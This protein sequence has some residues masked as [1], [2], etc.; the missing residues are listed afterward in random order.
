M[1]Q[2]NTNQIAISLAELTYRLLAGCHEKEERLAKVY[3]LTQAEF[4]CL[5]QIQTKENIN[6]K[7][8]ADRMNLSASRLTRI[9][10]GLVKKGFVNREI[11]P[12]DRRNMRVSLSPKGITLVEELNGAYINVHEQ[13]LHDIDVEQHKPLIEGMRQLLVALEKWISTS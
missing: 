13:I 1:S 4:R 3:G 12:N 9:I 5:R 11:D 6:N 2:E 10:D 8:I 7:E